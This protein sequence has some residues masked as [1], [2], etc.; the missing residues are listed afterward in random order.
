MRYFYLV[1]VL[2][3][4]SAKTKSDYVKPSSKSKFFVLQTAKKVKWQSGAPEGKGG[5]GVDYEL[6]LKFTKN[7]DGY[8]KMIWIANKYYAVKYKNQ[9][10]I[11]DYNHF[12][13]DQVITIY[14][15]EVVR[16]GADMYKQEG[17]NITDPPFQY[18][19]VALLEYEYHGKTYSM[20]IKSWTEEKKVDGI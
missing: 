1:L 5:A 15:S 8:F 19:G 6:T 17:K 2:F 7:Y 16:S 9:A 12:K 20:V 4:L 3:L 13:K 18:D 14:A 10:T 11:K